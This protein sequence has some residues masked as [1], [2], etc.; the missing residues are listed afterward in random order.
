M[1][2]STRATRRDRR[3]S[4]RSS[5]SF[6]HA[7]PLRRRAPAAP[8]ASRE[9]SPA[10]KPEDSGAPLALHAHPFD[11]AFPDPSAVDAPCGS[12]GVDGVPEAPPPADPLSEPPG[13]REQRE[14]VTS[15]RQ[16]GRNVTFGMLRVIHTRWRVGESAPRSISRARDYS[17]GRA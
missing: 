17:L 8:S 16:R 9:V 12:V 3:H 5:S 4:A 1:R 7:L 15:D 10:K 11:D 14:E 13:A 2:C 6:T